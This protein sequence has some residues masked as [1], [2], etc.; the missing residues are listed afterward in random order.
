LTI[1]I[2]AWLGKSLCASPSDGGWRSA[3]PLGLSMLVASWSLPFA[4]NTNSGLES[5]SYGFWLVAGFAAFSRFLAGPPTIRWMIVSSVLFGMATLTRPEGI[6]IYALALAI[7]VAHLLKTNRSEAGK[8][9]P[10]FLG[11]F[12]VLV[13]TASIVRVLYYGSLLPNTFYAKTEASFAQFAGGLKYLAGFCLGTGFGPLA[14]LALVG[15]VFLVVRQLRLREKWNGIETAR[16]ALFLFAGTLVIIPVLEGGDWMPQW[17]LLVPSIP[18]LALVGCML[19]VNPESPWSTRIVVLLLVSFAL[20]EAWNL[21]GSRPGISDYVKNL[22]RREC[23]AR[24]L[25]EQDPS[26]RTVAYGDMGLVPYYN[27][28]KRFLD[29]NGL[30]D[31]FVA[32]H[33]DSAAARYVLDQ[34]PEYI[35]L[36]NSSSERIRYGGPYGALAR[37]PE[38]R[39]NYHF[40]AASLGFG[41]DS[42]YYPSGRILVLFARNDMNTE[43]FQPVPGTCRFAAPGT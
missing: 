17:R 7:L 26:E 28:S 29:V 20:L 34:G 8:Q 43:T 23:F 2:V 22:D 36:V 13:G 30:V 9:I 35:L 40:V 42:V 27:P 3:L 21:A 32:R 38:L 1:L 18:F 33:D 31:A 37:E 11:P 19:P 16:T 24:W 10:G 41:P 15:A 25:A 5:I 6:L 12:L 4:L 14:C 39:S